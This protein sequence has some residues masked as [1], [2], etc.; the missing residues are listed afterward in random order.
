[1]D[2]FSSYIGTTVPLR[3]RSFVIESHEVHGRDL[4]FRL[5]DPASGD[6]ALLSVLE[7]LELEQKSATAKSSWA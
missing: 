6:E 4:L 7:L 1:M 5:R 3:N 2:P